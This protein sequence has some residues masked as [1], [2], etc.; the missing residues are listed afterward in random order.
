MIIALLAAGALNAAALAAASP[1]PTPATIASPQPTPKRTLPPNAH[2]WQGVTPGSSTDSLHSKFGQ[3]LLTRLLP[4]GSLLDWY[5][6][7]TNNAYVI[8]GERDKIIQYVRAFPV[9]VAG[10][11]DGLKD[12]YGVQPGLDYT[13]IKALRGEAS[14]ARKVGDGV[15]VVLYPD[16]TGFLWLYEITADGVHAI[17]LYDDKAPRGDPNGPRVEDPH[18]GTSMGRAYQLHAKNEQEGARFERYYATHRNGCTTWQVANQTVLSIGSR[19][20]DQLD[21]QCQET[22]DETSMFFDVTSFYGKS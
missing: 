7:P 17:S 19:K 13:Q 2:V 12:P 18:D 3:P 4:D 15:A 1:S 20:I 22:K 11:L 9:D 6:G 8:V 5:P 14:G 10:S 16:D 21:L